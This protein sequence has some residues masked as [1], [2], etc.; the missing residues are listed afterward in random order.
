MTCVRENGTTTGQRSSEFFINHDFTHYA[1]ET[2]LE[3]QDAFFGLVAKGRDIHSFEEREE[4]SSKAPSLPAE[5]YQAEIVVG[6]FDFERASELMPEEEFFAYV[7]ARLA[8]AGLPELDLSREQILAIRKR[9]D[10]LVVRWR[11]LSP[12]EVLELVFP[13]PSNS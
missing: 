6:A 13:L 2:T 5:A 1:V 10:D 12:G 3:F 8:E 11:L 9:R 7:R 4:G